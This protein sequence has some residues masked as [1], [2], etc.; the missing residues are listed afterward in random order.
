MLL[1]PKS[2]PEI[3]HQKA[4]ISLRWL[5][6]ILAFYLTLFSP[7]SQTFALTAGIGLAFALSNI[8][9]MLI[10]GNRLVEDDLQRTI[11]VVDA[12]FISVAL[13][14]LRLPENDLHVALIAVVVLAVIWRDLRLVVFSL[15]AVSVLFGVF[16]DSG[17]LGFSL[18][19]GTE[20]LLTLALFFFASV[21]Y[22]FLWDRLM[23]DTRM[24]NTMIEEARLAEVMVEMTRALSS[25]LN[26]DDVLY[27][28]VSRL[29]QVLDAE[30]CSIFRIDPKTGTARMMNA[31][32]PAERNIE[33]SLDEFPEVQ[34][35]CATRELLFL[36]GERRKSIIAIPMVV[37]DTV[38]GLIEVR[39]AKIGPSLTQA[40]I[41]FFE[42]MASTA[43]N[44]LRNAQLFEEVEQRARTDYLTGLPNHRFFQATLTVEW[45]RSR[46]HDRP[47]SLLM[48][49]LD[50]LKSVNDHFGHPT[51]DTVIRAVAETIRTSC[52]AIDF[53][54]R[55]GGEEFT[56]ILPDTDLTG[57]VQAADRIREKIAALQV[58]EAG[59]ITASIGVSNY[60]INALT[61]ADLI[62]VADQALY[63]A[64]NG[65]RNRVAH[66]NY[67]IAH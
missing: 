64:K 37:N 14:A 56:V 62:R 45:G 43:A 61:Q 21:F 39:S 55:Y 6:V 50:F 57:A 23:W 9:L 66:F 53:S 2:H 31:S 15:L 65:G 38:L 22:I 7:G 27:S 24:S 19:V 49:D 41:R 48:I 63:A 52:R 3:S 60:P 13:I 29:R 26:T 18:N 32:K 28:I 67:Q 12:V 47:L 4:A 17:R 51:G 59:V 42:V 8:A 40:N 1:K 20:S 46:R 25:S 5:L 36:P 30:E 34:R 10:P 44:A 11:S 54:A 16:A 33:V 35:A 58:P